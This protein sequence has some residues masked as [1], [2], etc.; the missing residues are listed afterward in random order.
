M[1]LTTMITINDVFNSSHSIKCLS[2]AL[3]STL[4]VNALIKNCM[5]LDHRMIWLK[6]TINLDKVSNLNCLITYFV[7]VDYI[8]FYN[9]LGYNWIGKGLSDDSLIEKKIELRGCWD[10]ILGQLQKTIRLQLSLF[11]NYRNSY[12]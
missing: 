8:N 10:F 7:M 11:T 4:E 9:R 5:S 1:F 6:L 2:S 3:S 12:V